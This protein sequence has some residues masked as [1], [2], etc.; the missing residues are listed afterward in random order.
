MK[1]DVVDHGLVLVRDR[2][3]LLGQREDHVEVLD[4]NEVGLPIF[5]PLRAHQRLTLRAVPISTTIERD[6][7]VT[8]VITLLDVPTECGCSATLYRAHDAALP[9]TEG[10]NVLLTVDRPGL[11]EDIRQLKPGGTQRPPQKWT[12]GV[13]VGGGGSTLGNKSK[14]L[15][16]AHTVEVA[17]FK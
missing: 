4:G 13:G 8:T 15:V 5:Q 9:T 1:Q 16:V 17:T 2:R 14:G 10:I 12:G 3:D 7:L 11:A 6:T